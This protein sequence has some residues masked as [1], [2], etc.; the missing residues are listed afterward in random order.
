MPTITL[1]QA[2]NAPP[3]V[4]FD[5]ARD[6]TTHME[7]TSQ[8]E[9]RA[10]AGKTEGLLELGEVVTWE[11]T[12]FF[13]RQRLTAKIIKMEKHHSFEDVMVSG[14]FDSFTHEHYFKP[15]MKGGTIMT[16]VFHYQSPY[17]KLGKLADHLFLEAYMKKLLKVRS[18]GLKR[19]AETVDITCSY[20]M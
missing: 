3:E 12:H 10:V 7:T 20:E 5:L 4:C 14:A 16:D 19:K 11:A 1:H 17:G 8:S 6:V 13:I 15:T 2:I 9:E 18:L